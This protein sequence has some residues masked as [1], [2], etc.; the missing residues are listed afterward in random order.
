M[1]RRRE[2]QEM[3]VRSR[4]D[5]GLIDWLG[6]ELFHQHQKLSFGGFN[7][8]RNAYRKGKFLVRF[9][10]NQIQMIAT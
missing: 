7:V 9:A 8:E 10:V 1:V 5:V 6:F 3:A 4:D 2:E